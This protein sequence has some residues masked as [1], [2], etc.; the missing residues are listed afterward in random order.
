MKDGLLTCLAVVSMAAVVVPLAAQ[1]P[2]TL[3]SSSVSTGSSRL[4]SD[5]NLVLIDATVVDGD[6]RVMGNLRE[7]QFRLFE[8]RKEQHVK[9]VTVEEGPISLVVV[10]DASG[11]M[12]RSLGKQRAALDVLLGSLR[13]DDEVALVTFRDRPVLAKEFRQDG[14]WI[15]AALEGSE[16]KGGTA[17]LDAMVLA[18]DTLKEAGL[19]RRAVVLFTDAGERNS[20]YSWGEVRRMA[21]ECD[22]RLS[23]FVTWSPAD[24]HQLNKG[25][26]Q[27]IV[28]DTGGRL[29]ENDGAG[30]RLLEQVSRLEL[31]AQYVLAYTP[32]N[33]ERDGRFR[34]VVVELRDAP[35]HSK[36]FWKHGYFAPTE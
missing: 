27:D 20:R 2:L 24:D 34:H 17:L 10:F 25:A 1:G 5:T 35:K 7:D 4:R 22:G 6:D 8:D 14:D 15:R 13:P 9:S 28:N 12:R 36:V 19:R 23:A 16:A 31:H 11:S 3:A 18:M 29:F 30:P 21:R 33:A 32:G 26:L